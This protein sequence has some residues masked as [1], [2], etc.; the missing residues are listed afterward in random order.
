MWGLGKHRGEEALRGWVG[1]RAR[2]GQS[3]TGKLEEGS[4]TQPQLHL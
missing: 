3:L 4:K 1:E 2:A